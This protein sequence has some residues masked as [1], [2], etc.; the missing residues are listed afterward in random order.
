[1][2]TV[3]VVRGGQSE[4]D[5]SLAVGAAIL[6][7]LSERHR[8]IDILIDKSGDWYRGGV[9]MQETKALIGVDVAVN[10]LYGDYGVGSN[11]Q[12]VFESLGVPYT[13][14][15]ATASVIGKHKPTAKNHFQKSGLRTPPH[16]TIRQEE[17]T[18]ENLLNL[19]RTFH[20]PT[21][22]KTV[23]GSSAGLS[24]KSYT[25][26]AQSVKKILEHG[27][28]MVEAHITGREAAVG[29]IENFRGCS[30]YPLL[31]I[32]SAGNA[33]GRF[34]AEEKKE[35]ERMA[36]IAHQIIGARHY[37]RSNFIVS[38][39]EVY[40][41]E[42]DTLPDFIEGALSP[43]VMKASGIAFPDFLEHLIGLALSK[44]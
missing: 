25:E 1:M 30:L 20:N 42:I 13:G 28:A 24:A 31:P 38:P 27:D 15:G 40:I 37:S 12:K 16:R 7:N 22:V 34:S 14:S 32:D 10:A 18:P 29:V 6:K 11:A 2:T 17:A 44:R 39:H 9:A 43:K 23:S 5:K 36:M 33:P 21:F 19:F 4:Y 3:A 26:L 41:L 8:A 35:I